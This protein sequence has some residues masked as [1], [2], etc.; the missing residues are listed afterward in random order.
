M[1]II[2]LLYVCDCYSCHDVVTH[3][4]IITYVRMRS[5]TSI[6]PTYHVYVYVLAHAMVGQEQAGGKIDSAVSDPGHGNSCR[7]TCI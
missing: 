1:I 6:V 3:A 2:L 7:S 4:Q 5:H